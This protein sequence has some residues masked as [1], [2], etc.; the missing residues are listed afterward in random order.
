MT[1]ENKVVTK[2]KGYKYDH[3]VVINRIYMDPQSVVY[4]ECSA[5]RGLQRERIGWGG[6]KSC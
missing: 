1:R 6:D 2:E 5:S 4:K 3:I